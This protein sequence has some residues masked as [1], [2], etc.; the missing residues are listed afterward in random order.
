MIRRVLDKVLTIFV[1]SHV[2]EVG[3][4]SA[5]EGSGHTIY[6][7]EDTRVLCRSCRVIYLI[8]RRYSP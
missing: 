8:A 6:P 1:I 5:F 3:I 2:H 4:D 7:F